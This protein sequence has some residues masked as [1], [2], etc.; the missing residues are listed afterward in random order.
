MNINYE[1]KFDVAILIY[2]DFWGSVAAWQNRPADQDLQSLEEDGILILDALNK[3]YLD[4]FDEI[5]TVSFEQG[6]FR[7]FAA[8]FRISHFAIFLY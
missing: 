2:L 8:R 4:S 3:P 5:Q 6:V 1:N 7:T